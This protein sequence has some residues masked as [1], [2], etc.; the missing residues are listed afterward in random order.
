MEPSP[1]HTFDGFR[2]EPPPGGLWR[3]DVRLALRPRS[4]AML[5]YLVAHAGRLVT[6]AELRQHVWGGTHVSDT[7]LR[8]CVQEIRAALGDTAAAP[9]YLETVAQQGYR[10]HVGGATEDLPPRT[11]G[12]IV[13]REQDIARLED[14]FERAT[15][16]TRQLVFVSG[17]VGI[18]K[19]TVVDRF[20]AHCA[21]GNAGRIGRGQCAEH[22]GEGEPYL[23]VF[24]ALWQLG[25]GSERDA[26]LTVLRRYAP[27]WL[28]QLPGLVSDA[29][30]ER[31]QRQVAGA[32]PARMRRELAQA[33]E[34]L[35]AD[36]PLVLVLEDLQWSDRSTV[37]LLA[38]LAQRREPAQ[39]LVLGTYRPVDLVLHAHPLHGLVQELGGRG[40]VRDLPLGLLLA[41][42]V[43]AYLAGRLGGA[44]APAFVAFV[45]ERTDGHP[46]FLVTLVEHLVEQRLL[47]RSAGPW[48]LRAGGEARVAQ[49]PQE[50]RQLIARRLDTLPAAARQVLEVASVVGPAFAAA[51]VAAGTQ[52][53]VEA[54]DAVCD[55]VVTEQRVLEDTGGTVWPDGTRGGGYRFHHALYQ[56]VLYE[57]LGPTRR[58]QL[59]RQ[60][61]ARLEAGYGAQAG[62]I[63]AQL[64]RHFERG[65]EVARAVP[66][67]QQAADTATRR[68]AYQE[69]IAALTKGLALLATLPESP[70]RARHELT[71]LLLLGPRLMAAHGYAVPAVGESYT[72]AQTLAQQVGEPRQH[73]QALQGLS[74]FQLLRAQVRRAGAVCQQCCQLASA[75]HD[76]T[77]VQEGALDLGL[78][79]FYGG[80]PVTAWAQLEHSRRLGDLPQRSPLLFPHEEASGV[81]HSFYGAMVLWVLGYADQAQ[82]W[83]QDEL[84]RAQQGE[85]T[86]SLVSSHLFA[87]LLAQHR[88][89]VAATRA[90]A[91]ATLALATT[92][93]FAH[94]VAQGHIM[95]GW[96]LA[97]QGDA[98]TGVAQI[99]QGWGTVQ[100][101]GQQL[102]R[103]YQL[104]LLA[105]AYGQAGQPE[106]GLTCL[107]EAVTLMEATEERWWAAEV[108]RLQ[109][110]LLLRLPRPDI[111]QATACWHQALAVARHQQARA[112][113]LRTALSLSRLWQQ[114]GQRAEARELLAPVYGWFTEGFDTPDLLEA[115]ALLEE[116]S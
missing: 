27:L 94:R 44:V 34:V 77:L 14:W 35:T 8:V 63:A 3:G 98:A 6:K 5:R 104:A 70:A 73:G 58:A 37:D 33:L 69:A 85:H 36:A 59:H 12:P 79:A 100:R 80:D 28:V 29:E 31:V 53:T 115:K 60:V 95:Q 111:P 23:P 72:R 38:Y 61:G 101:F 55:G 57:A 64:A 90:S 10:L 46:L 62:D 84:A 109:G 89:D 30:V 56:Q 1:A 68:Q 52:D 102:Y 54:V 18:G 49:L 87:A 25:H 47:A 7:V 103:P 65:G 112:L 20:L 42:D 76:P 78:I 17:D 75:Q 81:H 39:L 11:A 74:R 96:A 2:L 97:M 67:L 51:A 91:E 83:G 43:A 92:H 22:A 110:A 93:G 9:Q 15:D 99:T 41:E 50:V 108:Y 105:E 40:L 113:E 114:Q 48:T 16:G 13:G 26:I 45:H 86:P 4:L 24:E 116:L 32:T 106:A 66:Y 88:R 107:A 21:A 82:H 19:T 71:L